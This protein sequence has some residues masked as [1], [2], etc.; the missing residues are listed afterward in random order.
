[1]VRSEGETELGCP[2][3]GEEHSGKCKG[4]EAEPAHLA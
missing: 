4:P 1:M 3:H 2:D